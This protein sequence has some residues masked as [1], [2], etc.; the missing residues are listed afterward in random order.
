[1]VYMVA[2][3]VTV[4][5]GLLSMLFQPIIGGVVASLAVLGS[6]AVGLVFRIP[7]IGRAWRAV[8][9]V[10]PALAVASVVL[11]CFGSRWGLTT[12][13]TEPETGVK[14]T[15]LLP[16]VGITSYLVMVFVIAN[17]PLKP[18]PNAQPPSDSVSQT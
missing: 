4:Y 9:F 12:T 5:D 6:L 3:I 11:M 1:M 7:A 15:G 18:K 14:T 2:M 10:A 17:W 13:F 16:E 8:W